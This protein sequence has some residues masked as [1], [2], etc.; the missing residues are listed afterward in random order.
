M[1]VKFINKFI[2]P[3]QLEKKRVDS[4]VQVNQ[5]QKPDII[6][7]VGVAAGTPKLYNHFKDVEYI[8]VDPLHESKNKF[9]SGKNKPDNYRFYVNGLGSK[10]ETVEINVE[11]NIARS[12]VLNRTIMS[13]SGEIVEQRTIDIITGTELIDM[14][15]TGDKSL[16]IKI[17]TEGFELEIVKG[18]MEKKHRI[19]WFICEVSVQKRFENSYSF[20]ELIDYLYCNSFEVK[21][22]LGSLPDRD[23]IVRLLDIAFVN[24]D[25]K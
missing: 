18:F 16:G 21:C 19:M 9:L 5:L 11:K 8:L 20:N 15:K 17:D 3:Y 24:Q 2:S 4:F 14:A 25:F 23:G 7:D 12:S 6:I 10:A 1:I 13:N 22:I